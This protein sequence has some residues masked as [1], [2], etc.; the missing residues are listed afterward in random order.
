M[1]LTSREAGAGRPAA[2]RNITSLV[3]GFVIGI[4]C[5]ILWM[6]VATQLTAA[7]FA[8]GVVGSGALV[9]LA[10]GVWIRVADL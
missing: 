7:P 2:K 8:P 1:P 6:L 5:F 10:V 3:G 4:G 9:A